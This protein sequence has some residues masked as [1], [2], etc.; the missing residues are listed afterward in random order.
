[1]PLLTT[2]LFYFQMYEK[3]SERSDL[4]ATILFLK[5]TSVLLS[6]F[7]DNRPIRSVGDQ[8][9]V[10]NR[11]CLKYF[12][13]WQKQEGKA[14]KT[15]FISK[16][17]F[18]DLKSMVVGLEQIVKIKLTQ[19]PIGYVNA[20][21]TNTDVVENFFS[22]HRGINGCNNNPTVLQ[23]SKG[24]NTIIISRKLVSTRSNAGGKISVG[25]AKPF[26]MH[27]KKVFKSVRV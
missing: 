12:L 24:V 2:P 8:R 13:D 27:V 19:H 5:N 3:S 16:E 4:G 25:G 15:N 18:D 22:S 26:K 6:N 9:L 21:R 10:E 17:C 23:Y 14:Y 1:M 7:T 11:E 20:S